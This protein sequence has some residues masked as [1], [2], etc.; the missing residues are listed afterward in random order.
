M[1]WDRLQGDWKQLVGLAK[2]RWGQL[3]DDDF[4]AV[5][6][7]REQL[8]CKIQ[9]RYGIARSEAERQIAEWQCQ[10]SDAWFRQ[11]PRT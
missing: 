11:P 3:T 4:D 9:D 10:A 2:A 7:R 1:N 8:A 5:A 6:G